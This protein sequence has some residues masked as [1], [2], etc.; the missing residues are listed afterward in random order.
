MHATTSDLH[1]VETRPLVP[2]ELLHRELPLSDRA[3]ATVQQA[4]SAVQAILHGRD[5]R[6]LVIVGPCSVHDVEAA[7]EYA[8]FITAARERHRA[9]LE[10]VMRVYFEKP[11]TTVGWKGLI[12]D[13][14]LDGSYD[15]N[16]GLRRARG[17]LLHLA[18]LGLPAASELL[19]PVVPQY[20]AD[21]ISWTAIGART[22][23]SQTHREMASGLSM[24]IGFKNGTDGSAST[25]INAMEA[26][27]KPH[28]F[29][30]ISQQGN[31]AI[32][33][34]TGN[35]DGHLV[36]RGGKG[37]PNYGPEAVAAAAAQL[38]AEGLPA[39]LMVDCSHGNSNKDYRRQ[40]EVLRQ[41]AEQVVGGSLHVMGVMLE[42]H[43]VEGSQKIPADLS[44]LTYGQSIT[45]A[46]IALDTTLALLDEL[47]G[48]VRTARQQHLVTA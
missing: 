37:G 17:L 12:N 24:P 10:V 34:T 1:V 31:A 48:A 22:T 42:S 45:D 27:A 39:R 32:V 15:I 11:R 5:Q 43:L 4:R 26:A 21:L 35:P 23:E 36:L 3:A 25:A 28:H 18:E 16:T 20:I 40:G 13:P 30:G 8:G 46:C 47:A 19:D 7:K 44:Q 33:S 29:L 41:V 14:H 38:A 2:P 9:E 6:L